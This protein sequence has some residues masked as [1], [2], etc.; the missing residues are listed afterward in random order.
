MRREKE[1]GVEAAGPGV[2]RDRGRS[3]AIGRERK[4]GSDRSRGETSRSELRVGVTVV[5][6][7]RRGLARLHKDA[8]HG[9]PQAVLAGARHGVNF[10]LA[11]D[12]P[13][14]LLPRH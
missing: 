13:P 9:F 12:R 6:A 11:V 5:S 14:V 4:S 8:L 7:A 3:A 1:V 10:P 2:I